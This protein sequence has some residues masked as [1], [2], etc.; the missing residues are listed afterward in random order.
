VEDLFYARKYKTS[1]MQKIKMVR[2]A[3]D[4]VLLPWEIALLTYPTIGQSHYFHKQYTT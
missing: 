1:L 4:H 3:G 2:T